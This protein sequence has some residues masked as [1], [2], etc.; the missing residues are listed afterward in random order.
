MLLCML[1]TKSWWL[2]TYIS[3]IVGD[4]QGIL[5]QQLRPHPIN[6]LNII[7]ILTD[8]VITHYYQI[9]KSKEWELSQ[10]KQDTNG[11]DFEGTN[12]ALSTT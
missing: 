1:A 10:P 11:G 8:Y 6:V 3:L 12:F 2:L 9:I 4:P 7:I 5:D